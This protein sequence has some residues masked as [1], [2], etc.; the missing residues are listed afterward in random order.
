MVSEGANV[1]LAEF[2]LRAMVPPPGPLRVTVQAV[3]ESGPRVLELQ[4]IAV[5]PELGGGAT[6]ESVMGLEKPFIVPVTVTVWSAVKAVDVAK[7]VPLTEPDGMVSEAGTVRLVEFELKPTVPPLDP[8]RVTVQALEDRG[9]RVVGLHAMALIPELVGGATRDSVVVLEE[10]FSV[11]VTV[12][13]WSAVKAVDVAKNVP[14]AEPDGMV[15]EAGSV[16][17]V[18]FELRPMVPPPDPLRVTVQEVEES[19]ASVPGLQVM[20]VIPELVGGATSD[21]VIA[22]EAPANVPVTVTV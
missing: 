14:L 13:V 11:P 2:E 19:G 9:A 4:P 16:R 15:T 20:A 10:P 8:L 22:L 17:L 3:E 18:E 12:T 7:N 5:I 6:S 1:R 21:S